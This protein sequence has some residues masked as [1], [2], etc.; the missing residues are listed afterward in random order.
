[1]N[2]K[3]KLFDNAYF[4]HPTYK[5][6][7][8]RNTLVQTSHIIKYSTYDT[9]YVDRELTENLDFVNVNVINESVI[10]ITYW[11]C[12]YGHIFES[13]FNL[14]TF[15]SNTTYAN[16]KIVVGIP[17]CHKNLIELANYLFNAKFINAYDL[18]NVQLVKFD[19]VILI[20]NFTK[21]DYFF[22]FNNE[23]LKFQIRKYY[24]NTNT[25]QYRNVFLTRSVHSPHDQNSILSNLTHVCD[26]FRGHHFK[27]IDPQY[28]TDKDLY[29]HIK[30]SRNI[31]TTNGSALCPIIVLNNPNVKVFCLNSKRYLPH[32]FNTDFEK[33]LW[34]HVTSKFDFTYIDSYENKITD[35]QL[36]F[37][38]HNLY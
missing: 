8:L 11:P 22:K 26:F 19:N 17:P 4:I 16:Y 5:V 31:I 3:Y 14:Y 25:P 2:F 32:G 36:N 7:N 1:M 28:T 23:D 21:H 35:N 38:I 18:S 13:L 6:V 20:E 24:D 9:I 12:C 30:N 34:K 10:L 37:I 15:Y 29:N 33:G 27:I